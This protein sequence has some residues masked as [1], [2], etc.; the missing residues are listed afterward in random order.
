M[1]LEAPI[2]TTPPI[3]GG[4]FVLDCSI[5]MAW[6]FDDEA[7]DQTRAMLASL[8]S[9]TAFVPGAWSL[10]VGNVLAIAER[11][12]R[13]TRARCAEFVELLRELPI[14]T[15]DETSARALVE[16]LD[17]AR[18]RVLTTYDAAYLELSMRRGVRLATR[19]KA[20]RAAAPHVGVELLG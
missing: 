11:K 19:D 18:G 9:Q 6:C 12:G 3:V 10:E 14:V 17:L 13:L 5:A 4:D 8:E 1:S 2:A 7:T 20:L 15:D 16:I